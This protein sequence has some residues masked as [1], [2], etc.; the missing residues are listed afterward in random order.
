MRRSVGR[1]TCVATRRGRFRCRGL[2]REQRRPP[3]LE[4]TVRDP[5]ATRMR[6]M[7]HNLQPP[8]EPRL[9]SLL[10]TEGVPLV[11]PQMLNSRRLSVNT[12]QEERHRSA[13]FNVC[14][15]GLGA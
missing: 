14:R 2:A 11:D 15:V 8:P 7:S 1:S 9:T 13:I 5:F 3:V 12:C 4:I 6:W 10:A